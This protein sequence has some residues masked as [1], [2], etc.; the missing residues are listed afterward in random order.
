MARRAPRCVPAPRRRTAA[1]R[2]APSPCWSPGCR[3]GSRGR[4]ARARGGAR[5]GPRHGAARRGPRAGGGARRDGAARPPLDRPRRRGSGG[6][7]LGRPRGVR[8]DRPRAP[9]RARAGGTA[10]RR[11]ST[12]RRRQHHV[13]GRAP[14]SPPSSTP[15]PARR[16]RTSRARRTPYCRPS[17]RG[18]PT[19]CRVPRPARGRP[20]GA[21]RR[22][23]VG[24]AEAPPAAGAGDSRSTT[25]R[26]S[27][28]VAG[29]RGRRRAQARAARLGGPERGYRAWRPLNEERNAPIR[30]LNARFGYRPAG[31]LVRVEAPAA[32]RSR[33]TP[34]RR[35]RSW[36][37]LRRPRVD[38]RPRGP[39]RSRR[40]PVR[41]ISSAVQA[42]TGTSG[43]PPPGGPARPAAP[44]RGAG[45]AARAPCAVAGVRAR[46]PGH[47]QVVGG[48]LRDQ[49]LRV[50]QDRLLRALAARLDRGQHAGQVVEALDLRRERVGRG[51][52]PGRHP[53]E[54]G[55][56]RRAARPRP[57]VRTPGGL[58]RMR[59]LRVGLPGGRDRLRRAG[60]AGRRGAL[61]RGAALEPTRGRPRLD[62]RSR[63][64][65]SSG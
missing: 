60:R 63:A 1:S 31:D 8:G 25:Y 33:R 62:Q 6:A 61:A 17:R 27:P 52:A 46:R 47:E 21:R 29:A 16:R 9:R 42:S 53:G 39:A 48:A 44:A 30:A 59:D 55:P 57:A 12:R 5:G 45:D 37:A 40:R 4:R 50:E 65:T 19:T 3:P 43:A 51:A 24:Y 10:S 41:K 35:P 56:R 32:P 7:R 20:R 14:S 64:R 38:R 11:Q 26:G 28:R 13:L 18:W 23:A 22:R 15:S 2:A 54:R 49:A 34:V 58:H 36:A